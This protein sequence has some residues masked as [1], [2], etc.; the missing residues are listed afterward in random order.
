MRI[1]DLFEENCFTTY[2]LQLATTVGKHWKPF[3]TVAEKGSQTQPKVRK[4]L[5]KSQ[6]CVIV[7]FWAQSYKQPKTNGSIPPIFWSFY[8]PPPIVWRLSTWYG[9]VWYGMKA[10]HMIQ[11]IWEIRPALAF[12]LSAEPIKDFRI[13]II[14][15]AQRK[16]IKNKYV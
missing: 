10:V 8:K 16:D 9:M 3:K 14:Q 15:S 11:I 2:L 13:E 6:K 7:I 12:I 5:F 4:S 1:E